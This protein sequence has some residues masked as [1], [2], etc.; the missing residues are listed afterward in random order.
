MYTF[1]GTKE[2]LNQVMGQQ[3]DW[4]K[5]QIVDTEDYPLLRNLIKQHWLNTGYG[6]EIIKVL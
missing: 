2:L 6:S 4:D 3:S 1:F 5:P